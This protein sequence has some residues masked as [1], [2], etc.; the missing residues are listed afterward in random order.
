MNHFL[1]SC[2][3]SRVEQDGKLYGKFF[4]GPCNAGQGTTLGTALRRNL[5]SE[6]TGIGIV[7]V[8]IKDAEHE[9]CSLPGIRESVLD[10]I[11]N[12]KGLALKGD[13]IPEEP[14]IGFLD[15]SGPVE[16]KAS[17]IRFP[18]GISPVKGDHH[19]ATVSYDGNL[20]FKIFLIKG[21]NS[22]IHNP[23]TIPHVE[24]LKLISMPSHKKETPIMI[25]Y[26]NQKENLQSVRASNPLVSNSINQSSSLASPKMEQS[27]L[28]PNPLEKPLELQY[29]LENKLQQSKSNMQLK[30]FWNQ[31]SQKDPFSTEKRET[32]IYFNAFLEL[33]QKNSLEYKFWQT[34]TKNSSN[35]TK[36]E[37]FLIPSFQKRVLRNWKMRKKNLS[38]SRRSLSRGFSNLFK[39][40]ESLFYSSFES[41]LKKSSI[42]PVDGLFLPVQRVNFRVE[43]DIS[44]TNHLILEIWTNG[45]VHPR[46]ALYE[47][48]ENLITILSHFHQCNNTLANQKNFNIFSNLENK[49]SHLLSKALLL[50]RNQKKEIEKKD[51][52]EISGPERETDEIV[53]KTFYSLD[54][55]NISLPLSLFINLKKLN[56]HT[57]QDLAKG[58]SNGFLNSLKEKEINLLKTALMEIKTK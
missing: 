9:Y 20:S 14:C 11:L 34:N 57:I 12:L 26:L 25:R 10:I 44:G 35:A 46:Q 58:L 47:S 33:L 23:S 43:T 41:D 13:I 55:A 4:I 37:T 40:Q 51:L 54:I 30:S 7:A 31:Y 50:K 22:M 21:K 53:P 42:L 15:V 16:V 56:I 36:N 32:S 27:N 49:R 8:E 45:A 18:L 24:A 3:E 6:I 28:F 1:V 5:L 19:I 2:L 38:K 17:H 29:Q 39:K 52:L 48:A